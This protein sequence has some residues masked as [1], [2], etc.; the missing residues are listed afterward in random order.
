MTWVSAY[1]FHRGCFIPP[2]QGDG[3]QDLIPFFGTASQSHETEDRTGTAFLPF[4]DPELDL[5]LDR[6]IHSAPVRD[7]PPSHISQI[8]GQAAEGPHKTSEKTEKTKGG[9]LQGDTM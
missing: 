5:M 8:P 3:W 2:Q 9:G 4:A 7:Q 1:Q 6:W